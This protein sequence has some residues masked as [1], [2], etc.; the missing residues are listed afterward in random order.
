MRQRLAGDP[1][2]VAVEVVRIVGV[3]FQGGLGVFLVGEILAVLVD[4]VRGP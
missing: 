2:V 1:V 3:R 4:R